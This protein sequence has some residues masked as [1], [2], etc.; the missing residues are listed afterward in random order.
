MYIKFEQYVTKQCL[1]VACLNLGHIL[2]GYSVGW[3]SPVLVK[4]FDAEQSPLPVVITT[5][6][7]SWIA[8]SFMAGLVIGI[9]PLGIIANIIGRKPSIVLSSLLTLTGQTL[10]AVSLD[11]TWIYCG[12]V[13]KGLGVSGL[14]LLDCLYI[15]EIASPNI[16]GI[17]FTSTNVLH[18]FGTL[19]VYA[20][21]PYVSYRVVSYVFI[22]INVAHLVSCSCFIPESPVFYV[23]KDKEEAAKKVLHELGRSKDID[24]ELKT[25]IEQHKKNNT[26]AKC[27][28]LFTIKNNRK[29]L[30]INLVL[31]ILN[32]GS[33]MTCVL[34]Y[35]TMIFESAGAGSSIA[36]EISS[37]ILGVTQ[38]VGA[39]VTPFFID[40]YGRRTLLLLS[41]PLCCLFLTTLGAYFYLEMIKYSSIASIRWLPLFALM[42]YL[43]SF[44]FGINCVPNVLLGET[45]RP[46]MRSLGAST[47]S[48]IGCVAGF[49]SLASFGPM[50]TAFGSHAVFWI[51][52]GLNFF[53]FLF[54]FFVVPETRG[55][56]LTE[57]ERM[58]G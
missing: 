1:I 6:E 38:L 49:V 41:L 29:A 57:I 40:K 46:N 7:A 3:S 50:V 51:Y 25:M 21:G 44:S 43:F 15:G 45:F 34:F 23:I 16:R 28:Q 22:V 13:I 11:T 17:L 27:I 4:L 55:R 20:I 58:M 10:L 12:Q 32:Q 48:T 54:T 56:S 2:S 36:P 52:A 26:D 31:L 30:I 53:G 8:S 18:A 37:M 47:A 9:F 35:A 19:L 39:I 42:A 5:T 24:T 33:G 14:A